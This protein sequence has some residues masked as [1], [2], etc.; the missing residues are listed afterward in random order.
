VES[1]DAKMTRSWIILHSRIEGN[2][3]QQN[4]FEPLKRSIF[5]EVSSLFCCFI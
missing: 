4:I 3:S 2:F 5:L 1:F